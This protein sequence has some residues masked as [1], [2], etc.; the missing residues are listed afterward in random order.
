MESTQY[1]TLLV[2][3]LPAGFAQRSPPDASHATLRP[4]HG[5]ADGMANAPTIVDPTSTQNTDSSATARSP[6]C[7][8]DDAGHTSTPVPAERTSIFVAAVLDARRPVGCPTSTPVAA[9]R[10]S[11]FVAASSHPDTDSLGAE[12]RRR[13]RPQR[14][15][16]SSGSRQ[17]FPGGK[18][19]RLDHSE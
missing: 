9:E 17:S 4:A 16:T 13:T 6:T 18:H 12:H 19:G 14:P 2:G 10:T 3:G 7:T 11:I 8:L 5:P 1:S 15:P